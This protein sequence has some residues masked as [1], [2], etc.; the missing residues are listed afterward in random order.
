MIVSESLWNQAAGWDARLGEIGTDAQL[1]MYFG[2]RDALRACSPYEVLRSRF[3]AATIVGCSGTRTIVG[4][5]IEEDVVAVATLTFERTSVRLAR[6]L[7]GA[8]SESYAAGM[9]LGAALRADDLVAAI[10]LADGLLVDGSAL[11]SGMNRAL[12]ARPLI[13]GGMASDPRDYTEALVGA[14][15]SP[16]SGTIAVVGLYG[17]SLLVA[18][19]RASGWDAFGPRRRV[20]RSQGN[21]VFEL[22]GKPAYDLYE[23]YLG[24]ELKSRAASDG[25]VI[26]LQIAS[27]ERPD[28][29]L[30]R[31]PLAVDDGPAS[32]TFAGH[33]PEGWI[34]RLM[35]GSSDRLIL[36]AGDAAR[37]AHLADD[38]GAGDT[39][40]FVVS[41]AG[42]HQ[43]MG[44]RTEEELDV[45]GSELGA[46]TTRLGFYSF[47]EIAPLETGACEVHNQTITITSFREAAA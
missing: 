20:T 40:A 11:A 37:H 46:A 45:V 12:G 33:V 2:S 7:V 23:R 41:C 16:Q 44:Q 28:A 17:S 14:N 3:P 25:V 22:D 13:V 29:T 43:V 10:V 27:P 36:G 35:R 47:G 42:R 6:A 15:A 26:P 1:V 8:P 38:A 30:V 18:H 9:E 19:G 5:A 39:F 24:E 4:S 34:A 32:M 31:A 21:V